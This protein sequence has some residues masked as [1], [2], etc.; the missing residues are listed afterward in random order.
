M[1]KLRNPV[2]MAVIG[3]PHGVK[4][5]VRLKTFTGDPEAIGDYGPLYGPD[6]R[7]FEIST[8]RPAKDGIVVRFSGVTTRDEAAALTGTPLFVDRAALPDDLDEGEFYHAD[9]IGL[10]VRDG[11]GAVL[12]RVVAV[13]DFGGGDILDVALDEGRSVMLP[14]SAA[15]VPVV[16]VAGGFLQVDRIASGLDEGGESAPA[17]PGRG[18]FDA[19]KR[20]RGP[21]SA[22]GNR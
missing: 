2:Q 7:P 17:P 16:D 3:A 9:L 14:F 12:G 11:T 6:G 20:P 5:E 18:R 13:H 8:A 4:G 1:P 22:G 15:A 21:R 19:A 10:S